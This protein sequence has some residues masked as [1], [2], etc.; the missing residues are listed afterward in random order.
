MPITIKDP[1]LERRI[2]ALGQRQDIP[3]N[4]HA[5]ALAIL[6]AACADERGKPVSK[7]RDRARR[8]SRSA[9]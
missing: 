6:R 2:E 7:W 4:K 9:A 3:A 1:E 8:Y 5:M